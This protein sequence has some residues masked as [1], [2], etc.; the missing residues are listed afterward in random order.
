MT[1][2]HNRRVGADGY[3]FDSQAERARYGE[4][5][6]LQRAGAISELVV[7]PRYVLL[8]KTTTERVTVYV[9]DF[10]YL[11][12]TKQIVEDVKGV[13]TALWRLK[14][15]MFRRRYPRVELRI[16]RV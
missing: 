3:T 6:L 13:E 1:K 2:Y 12:G 16:V 5:L 9:A 11:D 8:D 14:M 15:A 4:L 7:H 10:E